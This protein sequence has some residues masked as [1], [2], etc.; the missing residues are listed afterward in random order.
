MARHEFESWFLS[1]AFW[2]KVNVQCQICVIVAVEPTIVM[3]IR[4]VSH[5]MIH[6][7]NT[8]I[9]IVVVWLIPGVIQDPKSNIIPTTQL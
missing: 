4:V 9:S 6:T 7:K 5:G 1:Q 2:L 8:T 3:S